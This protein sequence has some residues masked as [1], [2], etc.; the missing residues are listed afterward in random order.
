MDTWTADLRI[1]PYDGGHT[2][3]ADGV[4]GLKLWTDDLAAGLA[5]LPR[6]AEELL[7]ANRGI[8]T[9]VRLEGRRLVVTEAGPA[10]DGGA[11]AG[12]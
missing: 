12:G 7:R 4:P 6:L 9:A 8:E 11:A 5:E 10:G 2:V 1:E 3:A